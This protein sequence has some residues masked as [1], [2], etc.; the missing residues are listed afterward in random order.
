MALI[1]TKSLIKSKYSSIFSDSSFREI[2]LTYWFPI[3]VRG[4]INI[5]TQSARLLY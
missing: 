4:R 1:D 3:M 2:I 5:D